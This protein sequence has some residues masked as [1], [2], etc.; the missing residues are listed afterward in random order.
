MLSFV[1]PP[2]FTAVVVVPV[3]ALFVPAE[4][5]V[6][7][8]AL[9]EGSRWVS[10]SFSPRSSPPVHALLRSNNAIDGKKAVVRV[11][12]GRCRSTDNLTI[13]KCNYERCCAGLGGLR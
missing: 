12:V 7:V 11:C 2:L 1:S 8:S 3:P 9:R 10:A 6:V 5:A 4:S 13:L